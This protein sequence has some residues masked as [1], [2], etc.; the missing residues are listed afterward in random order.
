MAAC[1]PAH[2][3]LPHLAPEDAVLAFGDSLTQGTGAAPDRAYPAQLESMIGRRVVNAGVAGET[4]AQGLERLPGV[5]EAA[6]PRLVLLCLGGNDML[7]GVDPARTE[8]NLRRM[9]D[10]I[11]GRGAAVVLIAVPAPN[12]LAGVPAF[13]GRIAADYGIPLEDQVF[14]RVLKDRRLKSD[15]VHANADG[16]RRVAERLAKLLRASGA[17]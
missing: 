12:L 6:A 13:Y 9:I 5:L 17:V 11:R 3:R 7:Q 16:Y 4:T 8:A 2:P 1:H 15:P 14:D 10:L